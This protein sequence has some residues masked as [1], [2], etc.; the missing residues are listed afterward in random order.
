MV[1]NTVLKSLIK[2]HEQKKMLTWLKNHFIDAKIVTFR[3]VFE[4]RTVH[5]LLS[6]QGLF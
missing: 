4:G 2:E 1:G 5:S 3:I 6:L